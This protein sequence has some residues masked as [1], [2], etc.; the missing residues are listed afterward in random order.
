MKTEAVVEP[1]SP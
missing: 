1:S